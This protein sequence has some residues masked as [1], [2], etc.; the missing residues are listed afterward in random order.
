MSEFLDYQSIAQDGTAIHGSDKSAIVRFEET[1]ILDEEATKEQGY[2][3]YK[4]ID[5]IFIRFAGQRDEMARQVLYEDTPTQLSDLKRFPNQW[6]AYKA[7]REQ[8]SD[9]FPITEWAL[10]NKAQALELKSRG[11]H[12]VEQLASISDANLNF[13]GAR[14]LRDNAMVWLDDAKDGSASIKLKAEND[15]LKLQI[16]ALQNQINAISGQVKKISQ[17]VKPEIDDN[18]IVPIKRKLNRNGKDTS[19]VSAS[20]G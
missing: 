14:N 11:I 17:E 6:A 8:V 13:M 3:K 9:G 15:E 7:Q 12:T 16:Q 19:P 18:D 1:P 10:L 5:M 2:P 20:G 4:T